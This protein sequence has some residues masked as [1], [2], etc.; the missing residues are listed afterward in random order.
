MRIY[1]VED[2]ISI[3]NVLEDIIESQD[4]GEI[5]GDC[6]GQP[7]DVTAI[8][9]SRP[10]VLLVDFFMPVMDGVELVK[11]V[12]ALD[13]RI[14]CIM[15]SQVSAKEL[16]SKAYSAGVDF[17]IT[18]PI[19]LIEVTSVLR[20]VDRQIINE[21]TLNN[22]RKMFTADLLQSAKEQPSAETYANRLRYILNRLG[23]SGEKGCSDIIKLCQYL[24]DNHIPV[25][26]LS[27]AQLCEALS[28]SPKNMEQRVRRAISAGMSNIAHMGIEDFMNET[29]TQYSGTLFSFE[30]VRQ[31]MERIRGKRKAGG[32]VSIK[33]FVDGLML[34][35]EHGA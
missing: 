32:K 30:D 2:D 1:I 24:H 16:V 21:R 25:S 6:G 17:F 35:V 20:N 19:N 12:R 22:I 13:P 28:D 7:A 8:L 15:I 5:C 4:L 34:E 9:R 33:K 29:F 26:Q 18:K 10:D 23:M 31:E 27:V 3:I 14:K 11:E